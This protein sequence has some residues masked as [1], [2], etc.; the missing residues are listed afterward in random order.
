MSFATLLAWLAALAW[1]WMLLLRG[2][3]WIIER[4]KAAPGPA[5]W[6]VVAALVPARDEA[7]VIGQAVGSLLDQDYP[8]HFRVVVTDDHSSDG[9]ARLARAAATE[10]DAEDRLLVVEAA[11]LPPGWSGKMWAQSQAL[12]AALSAFPDTELLL[13]TDADIGHAPGELTGMVARLLAEKSDMASLMVR[14]STTSFAEKAVVPAFVFFFR[15]LYPFRWIADRARKTAGAAGGYILIRRTMLEKIGGLAAIR[16][17]LID[18]CSLAATV[19][20]AGGRVTLDLS[21]D[22]VSLRLYPGVEGLWMM[23]ARSAY[24]Q[25]RCSPL[26]LAGTVLAMAITFLLPPVF[27]VMPG[28]QRLPALLAWA[29][30][31]LAFAPMLRFYRLPLPCAPLLPLTALFYLGATLDS[32]RR[33]WQGRGGEWKGRVQAADTTRREG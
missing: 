31:S 17:A 3:F 4:P 14:L 21:R 9:T 12:N 5:A 28:P 16:N 30:L 26:L 10:R 27:T 20:R 1:G 25:L 19:K 18:D 6:P 7:E 15:L 22:T 23:I 33:H 24:T 32:A 11:P 13:L 2:R 8:G 29:E